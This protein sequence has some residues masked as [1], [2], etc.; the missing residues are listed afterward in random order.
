MI[1][2]CNV[3]HA[4]KKVIVTNGKKR[5]KLKLNEWAAIQL[6]GQDWHC[7]SWKNNCG[8]ID[9]LCRTQRWQVYGLDETAILGQHSPPWDTA[10]TYDTIP[11]RNYGQYRKKNKGFYYYDDFSVDV[12]G[13]KMYFY[14]VRKAKYKIKKRFPLD[15]IEAIAFPRNPHCSG[16]DAATASFGIILIIVAPFAAKD[17]SGF[18]WGPWAAFTGFGVGYTAMLYRYVKNVGVKM[19]ATREF[20]IRIK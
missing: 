16:F 13:G 7:D 11:S 9:S 15:S 18:H 10:Y 5:A 3:L 8:G 19:Y 12:E 20:E 14:I 4:Q 2:C 17:S 6:K 1:I